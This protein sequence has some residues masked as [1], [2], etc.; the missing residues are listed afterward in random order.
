M[1]E[2]EVNNVQFTQLKW[3]KNEF[4]LRENSVE[5]GNWETFQED[6]PES[7]PIIFK[8]ISRCVLKEQT[9]RLFDTYLTVGLLFLDGKVYGHY[10]FSDEFETKEEERKF[11]EYLI[12]R[13]D[14]L[15]ASKRYEK[16]YEYLKEKPRIHGYMEI[17]E[18]YDE[19]Q[20]K[21]VD[22]FLYAPYDEEE[23][24]EKRIFY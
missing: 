11:I 7:F 15:A 24:E 20:E 17:V 1:F 23:D 8:G 4:F 2:M 6:I 5:I 18:K 16:L 12:H 22:T 3:G 14:V 21:M 13:E 9:D 10:D 19:K